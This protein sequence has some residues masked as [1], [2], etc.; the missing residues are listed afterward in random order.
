MQI[1]WITVAAQIANFLVLVWL[2]QR[3]LYQPITQAMTRR[4][5]EIEDRLAEAKDARQAAEEEAEKL[6][7]RQAELDSEK[8]Q[9]LEDA[10][11]EAQ[12]S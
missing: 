1:D 6:R 4:E 9:I 10:K 11:Q 12:P 5:K 3:F 8:D 7:A 2:L